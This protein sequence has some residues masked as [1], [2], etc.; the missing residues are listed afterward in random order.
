MK[1]RFYYDWKDR[2]QSKG[3]LPRSLV[4]RIAVYLLAIDLLLFLLQQLLRLFSRTAGSGLGGWIRFLTFLGLILLAIP[5]FRWLRARVLWRLRNRLIVTYIFIGVVP[6]ALL[7][8]MAVVSIYLFAGQ[9]ATFVVTT[10][11]QSELKRL[12]A[13]NTAIAHELVAGRTAPRKD[14]GPAHRHRVVWR[15][16]CAANRTGGQ[17]DTRAQISP[18]AICR[19]GA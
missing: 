2:L 10:D 6:V 12:Q 9:F 14:M 3:L 7:V 19:P 15:Q 5:A 1:S 17:A 8:T 18:R 4:G 13:S 16:G 11:I